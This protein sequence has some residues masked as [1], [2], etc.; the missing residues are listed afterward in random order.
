[1][2]CSITES[3]TYY[4]MQVQVGRC[5]V[6]SLVSVICKPS[7]ILCFFRAMTR[8]QTVYYD[9]EAWLFLFFSLIRILPY[10]FA[11]LHIIFPLPALG[12]WLRVISSAH[13]HISYTHFASLNHSYQAATGPNKVLC[14]LSQTMAPLQ[15]RW[16]V[17]VGGFL[18]TRIVF[19]FVALCCL[20]V[21]KECFIWFTLWITGWRLS[22]A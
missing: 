18:I 20:T 17:E 15:F 19:W 21:R 9:E 10:F 3:S 1:M 5:N 11:R 13:L 14:P 16:N 6:F 2:W 7:K 22:L 12:S 4:N 8:E